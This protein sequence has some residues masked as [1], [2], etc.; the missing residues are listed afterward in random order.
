MGLIKITFDGSNVTAKQ[1]ADINYHLTGLVA[2]G[3]IKGLGNMLSVSVSNN[4]ITFRNGYVQ[5]Y[6]RRIYVEEGSQVYISLDSAKEG[7]VIIQ[8]DLGTN[9][10][11]L[12]KVEGTTLPTLTQQNLHNGGTIYQMP[13]AKYSKTA[14]SVTLDTS[15]KI[16]YITPSDEIARN[17]IWDFKQKMSEK[18]GYKYYG[19]WAVSTSGKYTYCNISKGIAQ[20]SVMCINL[21]GTSIFIPGPCVNSASSITQQYNYYG[22]NYSMVCEWL[23]DGRFCIT[24]G[25]TSHKIKSIVLFNH[26]GEE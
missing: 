2:A 22:T 17:E 21:T 24:F 5:I 3:V 8:V 20:E 9:N 1:D 23:T 26:G 12:T 6:G 4:Y 14:T 19:K 13:I 15:F 25:D 7:Y 16:N 11:S 10:V 18:Y